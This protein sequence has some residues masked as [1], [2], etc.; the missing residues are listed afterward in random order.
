MRST[1][2]QVR[3]LWQSHSVSRVMC[4]AVAILSGAKVCAWEGRLGWDV[5]DSGGRGDVI[6]ADW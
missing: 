4:A 6:F 3:G 5:D 2:V 1:A